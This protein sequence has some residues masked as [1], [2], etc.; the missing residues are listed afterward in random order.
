[1]KNRSYKEIIRDFT[2]FTVDLKI[3]GI[4]P[5]FH[6][7]GKQSTKGVENDNDNHGY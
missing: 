6:S 2:E 3:R 1:M 7:H 5:G 4:N